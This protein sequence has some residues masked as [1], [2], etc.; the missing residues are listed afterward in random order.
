MEEVQNRIVKAVHTSALLTPRSPPALAILA[1]PVCSCLSSQL[2]VSHFGAVHSLSDAPTCLRS[3]SPS[4]PSNEAKRLRTE[5][6][7]SGS[8]T[9]S[10]CSPQRIE[11]DPKPC[12]RAACV[13]PWSSTSIT[14]LHPAFGKFVDAFPNCVPS[15]KN[16]ESVP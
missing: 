6:A 10:E 7:S 15:M 13:S 9:S 1:D 16:H 4:R 14:F 2:H 12:F 5:H 8:R 11:H 3:I